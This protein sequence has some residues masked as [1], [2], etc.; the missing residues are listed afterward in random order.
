MIRSILAGLDGSDDS[1]AALNAAHKIARG[2][3]AELNAVFIEDPGERRR[4]V[5]DSVPGLVIDPGFRPNM[6][7]ELIE[8]EKRSEEL[9]R[10]A[11]SRARKVI[12]GKKGSFRVLEGD[13]VD[14]LL[15]EAMTVDLVALGASGTTKAGGSSVLGGVARRVVRS[16][17]EPV[18]VARKKGPPLGS[19]L[20]IPYNGT[21]QAHRALKLGAGISKSLRLRPTILTVKDDRREANALL[22]EARRTLKP[23]GV[24][25]T[26]TARKGNPSDRIAQVVRRK[27]NGLVVMG[28]YGR[29]RLA[30]FLLGSTVEKVLERI[31][32]PCILCT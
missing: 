26:F 2:F 32:C 27:R 3:R 28:A 5:A 4:V 15:S 6:P 30:E 25:A 7:R 17:P 12:R 18:L 19:P 14:T 10:R 9:L 21:F 8:M 16:S 29:S 24:R 13:S 31:T 23:Y 11:R 22:E 1:F 20:V